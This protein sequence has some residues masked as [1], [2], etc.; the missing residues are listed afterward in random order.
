MVEGENMAIRSSW[1]TSHLSFASVLHVLRARL[2]QM[3]AGP[4]TADSKHEHLRQNMVKRTQT[5]KV[6]GAVSSARIR[7]SPLL[8]VFRT[9]PSQRHPWW[10]S[11]VRHRG[12][13]K[14]VNRRNAAGNNDLPIK[15]CR[16]QFSS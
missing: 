9:A 3:R 4:H 14:F 5:P 10:E 11:S 8:V 1:G 13:C 7:I 12:S 16:S 2:A 6:C 15:A